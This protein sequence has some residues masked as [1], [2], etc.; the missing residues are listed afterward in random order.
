MFYK[1]YLRCAK[2]LFKSLL[3]QTVYHNT[4]RMC[5]AENT[6]AEKIR[7]CSWNQARHMDGMFDCQARPAAPIQAWASSTEKIFAVWEHPA[8]NAAII[9]KFSAARWILVFSSVLQL[10]FA[11]CRP[12]PAFAIMLSARQAFCLFVLFFFLIY[13]LYIQIFVWLVVF[14]TIFFMIFSGTAIQPCV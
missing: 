14:R 11:P 5:T 7:I 1:Q 9:G 4:G 6:D 12:L 2:T 13:F 10:F 8:G 3:L